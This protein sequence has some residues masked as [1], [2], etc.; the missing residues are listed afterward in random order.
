[1]AFNTWNN[2]SVLP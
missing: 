1:M 2:I